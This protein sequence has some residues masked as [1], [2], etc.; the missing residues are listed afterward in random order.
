MGRTL[1]P[2]KSHETAHNVHLSCGIQRT[3]VIH[4]LQHLVCPQDG[5]YSAIDVLSSNNLV[6]YFGKSEAVRSFRVPEV[7]QSTFRV[8]EVC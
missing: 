6:N 3:P 4:N 1:S 5:T 7:C 8:P 2:A